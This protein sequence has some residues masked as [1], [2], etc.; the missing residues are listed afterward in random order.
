MKETDLNITRR[1][2]LNYSWRMAVLAM[3]GIAVPAC[4][5]N[6]SETPTPRPTPYVIPTVDVLNPSP[7]RDITRFYPILESRQINGEPIRLETTIP[8]TIYNYTRNRVVNPDIAKKAFEYFELLAYS[9]RPIDYSSH[10]QMFDR[11]LLY[12]TKRQV[13]ERSIILVPSEGPNLPTNSLSKPE[14]VTAVTLIDDK[15]ATNIRAY[16]FIKL[17]D[18]Q[19]PDQNNDPSDFRKFITEVCQSTVFVKLKTDI[20][21][22]VIGYQNLS[23][24]I[25]CNSLSYEIED[26]RKNI[27]YDAHRDNFKTMGIFRFP[28]IVSSQKDYLSMPQL[29]EIIK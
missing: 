1:E 4:S 23:Q 5:S 17:D 16:I 14:D 18:V 10:F 24:E 20:P 27:S 3:L 15:E 13:A 29:G 8:T 7:Y 22:N 26:R 11:T 2:F 9:N 6:Q 12:L 21:A 19:N 28:V 25:L